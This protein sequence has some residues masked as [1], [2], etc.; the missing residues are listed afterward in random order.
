MKTSSTDGSSLEATAGAADEG[1]TLSL[2]VTAEFGFE[3]H[4]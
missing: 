2:T 1:F 3:S 4:A